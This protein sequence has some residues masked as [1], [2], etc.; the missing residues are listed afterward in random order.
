MYKTTKVKYTKITKIELLHSLSNVFHAQIR[1]P[2]SLLGRN[3]QF[4]GDRV[5]PAV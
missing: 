4:Y 5:C 3:S 1:N 2:V